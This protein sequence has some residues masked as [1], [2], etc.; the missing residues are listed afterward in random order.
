MF[1]ARIPAAL[2]GAAMALSLGAC[3][4]PEAIRDLIDDL[5]EHGG[6]P[7]QGGVG[8]SCG[9][10]ERHAR[11]CK[12]DL[13]C[14]PKPGACNV[15]QEAGVCEVTPTACSREFV[16]VCGCDG[17]TYNN[18]CLHRAAKVGLVH[19]GACGRPVA[20]EGEM[21]GGF[22]GIR[23]GEGLFCDP[24]ADMCRVFDVGGV[25]TALDPE[26][27]KLMLAAPVCGCDGQTYA[28]DCFRMSAGIAKASNGV[29]PA[30]P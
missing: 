9:G 11:A 22:A 4:D 2:F 14:M 1:A 5:R 29:C 20:K 25:C 26:A 8:A 15:A 24:P 6:T 28:N 13:H 17:Q 21:C 18:D 27:C 19:A 23:C 12:P 7:D 10:R 30:Q 3:D 16:P